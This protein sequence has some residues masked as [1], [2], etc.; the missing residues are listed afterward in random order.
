MALF[1]F[2][3]SLLLTFLIF[4]AAEASDVPIFLRENCTTNETFTANT[5]FQFNLKT[6]LSSL[7]SNATGTTEFYNTTVSGRTPSDTI[8]GL[9][10]CRGDV[11]PQLCRQCVYN[12]TQ[13]LSDTCK[14]G[15]NAIIWYDECMVRYSNRGFFSTVDTRPRIR[16]R[17]TANV[18]DTK[19]FVRLLYTTLNET[20]DEAAYST[21][22]GAKLYA[23]REAKISAF[24]TLYCLVQC[25]PDLSPQACRKCLSGVIGDLSWC[26][27]G[28]QGG[29]VLYPSCNFRYELYSF[30]RMDSPAP[31]GAVNLA[32]SAM[33][34]GNAQNYG[35]FYSFEQHRIR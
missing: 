5:T 33:E 29:R 11:P 19:S 13:R 15:K 35:S 10:L 27:P 26:C 28:S 32:N 22:N 20:A 12:A 21:S 25:T 30:Y 9:F 1:S 24:Q 18:T 34:K 16:L 17:N 14:F 7:S 6:L 23:T 8:Y 31:E 3:H 4:N 2:T